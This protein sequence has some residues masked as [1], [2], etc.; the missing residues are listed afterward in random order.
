MRNA[1]LLVALN[2]VVLWS[3]TTIAAPFKIVSVLPTSGP[4]GT[5]V[6][7]LSTGFNTIP[8][9]YIVFFGATQ[10]VISSSSAT[11][12]TVTVPSGASYAQ[13]SVT[14]PLTGYTVYSPA[15]FTVTFPDRGNI[16]ASSFA[17][18]V[19][20]LKERDPRRTAIS[21]LDGDG[22]PDIVVAY[23]DDDSIS[24]L[25]SKCAPGN[26]SF[27]KRIKFAAGRIPSELSVADLDG[28]GKPDVAVTANGAS[29][30]SI[31]RNI[32]NPGTI[33][34]A[35]K[36]DCRTGGGP[37]GI[38][39][40]DIDG[41]GKPDIVVANEAG[42]ISVL[43]NTSIVGTISMS[44]KIDFLA[45]NDPCRLAVADVDGDGKPDIVV[46]NCSSNTISVLCNTSTP[47]T[48]S[49]SKK[50]DF[51]TGSLPRNVAIGDLNDDGKPD[52]VVS[53]TNS[54][55]ISVFQ[56]QSQVGVISF[57][58]RIDYP[59]EGNPRRISIGDIDGDGKPDVAV[60][61]LA[62]GC[63]TVFHNS[64]TIGAI[65]LTGRVN[66][67]T[68]M[69]PRS[70]TIA[71]VDG[72]GRPDAV[73]T[74]DRRSASIL[75][76]TVTGI[77]P[78]IS[79]VSPNSG[80]VGAS[81]TISGANFNI[82]PEKNTVYFGAARAK[83]NSA[84]EKSLTVTVPSG[85]TYAPI[86]VTNASSSLSAYS[87][88]PF[89]VTFSGGSC[90]SFS[91]GSFVDTSVRY[92]WGIAVGDLDGDGKPDVVVGSGEVDSVTVLQNLSSSGIVTVANRRSYQVGKMP[93]AIT[94]ADLDG[95]GKL[96]IVAS[97]MGAF[98]VSVLRNTSA[99]G[100]V[101]LDAKREFRAGFGPTSLAVGDI[102]GDGK[103]DIVTANTASNTV[104]VL[105]NTSINGFVSFADDIEFP[106]G[107][108]PNGVFLADIDGDGKLDIVVTN[109]KSNNISI[110]RN[111]S[112]SGNISLAAKLDYP[113]GVSPY[114]AAPA[115]LD[116]DGKTD[117]VVSNSA[118]NTISIFRNTSA[119]SDISFSA[120]T[121][122]ATNKTPYVV[123]T[124]DIDGDGR[125][126]VA[127]ASGPAETVSLFRNV[128]TTGG[129]SL[130]A[131]VDFRIASMPKGIAFC[132]IDGDGVLDMIET[133]IV[134]P[135]YPY[136]TT[137]ICVFRGKQ[138]Q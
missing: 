81:V 86:S 58:K 121:E 12:L 101:S 32:S 94:I 89:D 132:D 16:T 17:A 73:V 62:S 46:T 79:S 68:G 109:W 63:L 19:D 123:A 5:S 41:D 85:S 18:P 113:V 134:G 72:D 75:R 52:I 100:S 24:V 108:H 11:S 13:I 76:N 138:V 71:D 98:S 136:A 105:R 30:V 130:A 20:Y 43:R 99:P 42:S 80:P 50:I 37:L 106:T 65:V 48:V 4:V 116:G 82:V 31:L 45:G 114:H 135:G 90:G 60:A 64:S 91:S 61:N 55:N 7:I 67:L 21:D 74:T 124:A 53:N 66:F 3:T 115:D 104:T 22:K 103:P 28:D 120:R 122:Y 56:N 111:I 38:A 77:I 57:A 15:A 84:S 47:G 10:A 6:T 117:V 44:A 70:V 129:V 25:R 27:E 78:S 8:S 131:S 54:Q 34:F 97:N 137:L 69:Q 59:T 119:P 49:F 95:D 51:Q 26:M 88:I 87:T 127:V 83:V 39:V 14:D 102:D 23:Y 133:G 126:D 29:S 93:E 2:L 128:S 110:L 33:A 35:P 112:I 107:E 1:R 118:S 92:P 96:D 36:T 40:A 125:P 9:K